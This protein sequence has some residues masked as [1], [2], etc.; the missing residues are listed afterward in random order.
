[1]LFCFLVPVPMCATPSPPPCSQGFQ[2]E[3]PGNFGEGLGAI[4]GELE[5]AQFQVHFLHVRPQPLPSMEQ[6]WGPLSHLAKRILGDMQKALPRSPHVQ[7][8]AKV[9]DA[10]DDAPKLLLF[11]N[12]L[13]N[14]SLTAMLPHNFLFIDDTL[15]HGQAKTMQRQFDTIHAH[16][17]VLSDRQGVIRR[18]H[19]AIRESTDVNKTVHLRANVNP[20]AVV[21]QASDLSIEPGVDGELF[22]APLRVPLALLQGLWVLSK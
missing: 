11:R 2:R 14:A 10:R 4:S 19:E 17:H 1:M 3:P 15:Q 9:G 22:E 6:I 8:C 21:H 18:R 16:I 20:G 5:A 13:E 7:E 12:V